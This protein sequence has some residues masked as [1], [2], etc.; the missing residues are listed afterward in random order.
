M[1]R[2]DLIAMIGSATVAWPCVTLAQ[3]AG[4]V[5][6]VGI[7]AP[8]PAPNV[9]DEAFRKA[10][11]DLGHVEGRDLRI[12]FRGVAGNPERLDV[13]A[14][15]LV[16]LEPAV[17]FAS[18]SEAARAL[19]KATSRIPIVMGSSNPLGVGAVSSLARPAGN[20]TGVSFMAPEASGKRLELLRELIPGIAK[21]A[22]VINPDDPGATFSLDATKQAAESLK[23]TVQTIE[24]RRAA[25]FPPAFAA[26]TKAGAQAIVL[27]PAPNVTDNAALVG[28]LSLESRL[29]AV[30]SASA[31]AKAGALISYGAN[32]IDAYRRA[33]GYVDK[34]LKGSKP[35]DLPVEQPTKFE[36]VINL[37]TAKAL[38]LT[39]PQPL[40]LRADEVIQ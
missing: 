7:L 18:G 21:V 1:K 12:E 9:N 27:L 28:R 8:R 6:L 23:M 35:S 29:P 37:K 20:V 11:L 26:A 30:S 40:L 16:K 14:A 24:A 36:L 39:I 22:V 38:G 4:R 3:A 32:L 33:A 5:S 31:V 17:L 19:M 25:D 34:I 10:L 15:S 13:L 2:R